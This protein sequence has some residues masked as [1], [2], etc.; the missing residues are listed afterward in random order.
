MKSA[1]EINEEKRSRLYKRMIWAMVIVLI[2]YC[3]TMVALTIKSKYGEA[4]SNSISMSETRRNQYK[5]HLS[6]I[7]VFYTDKVI[8]VPGGIRFYDP[9]RHRFVEFYGK[10]Y[11]VFEP[12][13]SNK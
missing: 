7:G 1:Y 13:L 6:G 8:S 3:I 2:L 4:I 12:I 5:V 9:S 10:E 11:A